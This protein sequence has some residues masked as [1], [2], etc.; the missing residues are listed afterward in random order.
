MTVYVVLLGRL[1]KKS[2]PHSGWSGDVGGSVIV[3]QGGPVCT[4]ALGVCVCVSCLAPELSSCLLRC[5]TLPFSPIN[6]FYNQIAP[7]SGLCS[8]ENDV[9]NVG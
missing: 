7:I 1:K 2:V 3:T 5:L 9:G 6:K 4:L 8:S